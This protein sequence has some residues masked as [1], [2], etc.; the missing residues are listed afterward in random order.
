MEDDFKMKIKTEAFRRFSNPILSSY[1]KGDPDGEL[2]YL[3]FEDS[4]AYFSSDAFMA[5][6]N[7]VCEIQEPEDNDIKNIKVDKQMFLALCEQYEELILDK[8]HIFS[9]EEERFDIRPVV[10]SGEI[11]ID[12][13]PEFDASNFEMYQFNSALLKNIRAATPYMGVYDPQ[14]NRF[15]VKLVKR[16]VVGT[17]GV[18]VF[19]AQMGDDQE[20]L[21]EVC[22]KGELIKIIST[23]A[24]TEVCYLRYSE[25]TDEL[26]FTFGENEECS[27]ATEQGRNFK[28]PDMEDE[29]FIKKFH[30]DTFIVLEKADLVD[31]LEFFSVFVK[32][33]RNER[34]YFNIK[35]ETT[36]SVESQAESRGNRDLKIVECSPELIGEG[37]WVPRLYVLKAVRS[38]EDDF[39][40]LEIDTTA[41]AFNAVGKNN[42]EAHIATVM[43]N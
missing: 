35:N 4:K 36:F 23:M 25:S 40:V 21:P 27:L 2:M 6:L 16:G 8:D 18:Q 12:D 43:L 28:I 26:Y 13:Y 29:K 11:P 10:I 32:N 14:V 33:E 5:K 20:E 17:D 34:I 42:K 31:V 9:Y 41:P 38:I 7:F 39:V 24:E 22:I 1:V 3:N 19:E 15:G 37:F 30:H